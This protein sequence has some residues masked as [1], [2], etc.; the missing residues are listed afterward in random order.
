MTKDDLACPDCGCEWEICDHP[1]LVTYWGSDDDAVELQCP[2]CEKEFFVA[3]RVMR[4]FE[5]FPNMEGT[6]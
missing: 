6:L 4:T 2:A 5:V 1:E 3:E